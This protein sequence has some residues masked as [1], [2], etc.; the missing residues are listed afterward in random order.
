MFPRLPV[1]IPQK[2]TK[3]L[4]K[5]AF[6]TR[7]IRPDICI[8]GGIILGGGAVVVAIADTWKN[9]DKIE[10]DAETIKQLKA[11]DPA[12]G[13][14]GQEVKHDLTVAKKR[15]AADIFK[16]YWKTAALGGTSVI[17]ILSGKKLYKRQIVEL[18]T[19]YASL[20]ESYRRYRQ[21]V[22]NEYGAEKDQEFM[23]GLKT[24]DAID[25]E[26]GEVSKKTLLS[27]ENQAGSIYARWLDEG[28]WDSENAR[29]IWYNK[30]YTPNKLDLANR[31]ICIQHECNDILTARGWL[32][33][34]T[35][36]RKLSLPLT[37]EGQHVGWVRGGIINGVQGD[38]FV[39]FGVFPDYGNGRYQIPINREF[40]DPRSN[41]KCPLLDF[42]VICIDGI[43]DNI[44]EYDN[45]SMVAYEK[46]REPGIN[47]S[48][49]YM[50]RWMQNAAYM[51]DK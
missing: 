49:E 11:L 45:A 20:L 22:I 3:A 6:K 29:W 4:G 36:Y 34:N 7:K 10:Q 5:L 18:S 15:M 17:L 14:S 33:L 43:W 25:S 2:V 30:L 21:N 24:V 46:R 51:D 44:F 31:L 35:V 9:K 19:M 32:D 1:R 50:D 26:T 16:T 23:Y 41:Q 39:D 28:K 40:L 13:V 12:E 42:N 37:E 48:L 47:G 27:N 8:I 38:D